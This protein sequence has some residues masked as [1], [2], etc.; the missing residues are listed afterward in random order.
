MLADSKDTNS[1]KSMHLSRSIDPVKGEAVA[2]RWPKVCSRS[3][4]PLCVLDTLEIQA[5]DEIAAV[6]PHPNVF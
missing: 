5:R 2:S 3:T 1:I 4:P 6:R